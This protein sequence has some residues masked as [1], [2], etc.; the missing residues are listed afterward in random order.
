MTVLVD[1]VLRTLREQVLPAVQDRYAR[2]QLFAVL[3][4]LHNLRDRVE[5]K[6]SLL[7]TEAES[8]AAVLAAVLAVLEE[9]ARGTL[10]AVV[11]NVPPAPLDARTLALRAAVVHALALVDPL[12][13]DHPARTVLAGHLSGQALRDVMVLKASL[14]E[15]ISKG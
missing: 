7:D 12:P 10:A 3:D 15:E 2:G 14:L 6:A 5:C 9:P 13:D 1:G 11:A 4:V 8:A